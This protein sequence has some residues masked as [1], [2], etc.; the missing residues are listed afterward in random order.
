V[1]YVRYSPGPPLNAFVEYLWSLSDTPSHAKELIMPSG[2][3][4]LVVNLKE[5]QIRVYGT[6]DTAIP[7]RYAGAVVSGA[8]DRSFVIDTQEHASVVG[9]HFRPGGAAPFLPA[10]ADQLASAHVS[11]A[12]LWCS[13]EVMLLRA[14]LCDARTDRARF[15]L[16]EQA[17]LGRMR[18]PSA[19]QS[20]VRSALGQMQPTL[21][22]VHDVVSELGI[23]HR[24]FIEIFAQEV[25]LTPKLYL[26]VQRFQRVLAMTARSPA[27]QWPRLAQLCGYFDQAHLIRDF[28]AFAGLTPT[29][30]V[31][32]R[33]EHVKDHHVPLAL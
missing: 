5:D 25:G 23:S 11:L 2:T 17:L 28:H 30:Y 19:R 12:E 1:H 10:P 31:R 27:P 8:F 6:T 24:R 16:L 3:L 14:R 15:Q 7:D 20:L 33:S 32:Q 9:V 22:S 18:R 26:R 13:G 4:E 21:K 29:Q